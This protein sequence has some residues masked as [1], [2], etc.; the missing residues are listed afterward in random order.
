[1]AM[2]RLLVAAALTLAAVG[3]AAA[4]APTAIDRSFVDATTVIPDLRV[5]LRYARPENF[6]KRAVYPKEAR[7]YLRAPVAA[8]LK[9]VQD[10]LRSQG[11]SLKVWDC[12]RP[13]GVQRQLWELVPDDRYV[14]DPKKGSRHNRG[15]ALDL[16]LVD[17]AARELEMPTA[18]DDFS[19]RAHRSYQ[20]L[21]EAARR[22]RARLE[23]A[24]S[25][26]GFVPLAT[27]W[28]HFDDPD[29]SQF[30]IADES[31]TQL[32]A[33]LPGL[34]ADPDAAIA[35]LLAD[36]LA[37]VG[38]EPI[39]ATVQRLELVHGTHRFAARWKPM[40]PEGREDPQAGS[41]APRCEVAAFRVNRL[42]LGEHSTAEHVVPPTVVR[43]LHRDVP[44]DRACRKL[45]RLVGASLPATF[46]ELNDHLVIGALSTELAGAREPATLRELW[47]PARARRSPHYLRSVGDT[48][49]LLFLLGSGE[50]SRGSTFLLRLPELDRVQVIDSGR[51]F[52]GRPL[53]GGAADPGWR[54]LA[55][56]SPEQLLVP[57]LRRATIARLGTPAFAP[58]QLGRELYL[59]A[60]V[61]LS[62][63]RAVATPAHEPSLAAHGARPLAGL[64]GLTQRGRQTYTG[65][66]Q[67]DGPPWLLLGIGE[68]GVRQLAE[69][70]QALYRSVMRRAAKHP[71]LLL[72]DGDPAP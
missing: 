40:E 39:G 34:P 23:A 19:E 27:E 31:F 63:G 1:M 38:S 21:P 42:L 9:K 52:D 36:D 30:P 5:E 45:P 60:A 3:T 6:T 70:A 28:W 54:P 25:A 48:L 20:A 11:L 33:T 55:E 4:E 46:P 8:R 15:A 7:C 69:R 58:A 65:K 12:Y 14:A 2:R 68:A 32:A 64:P 49:A 50:A 57:A 53:A 22:N 26:A 35:E 43:A 71:E 10:G 44:C 24:M 41:N 18:H 17:A 66:L 51:A 62:S 16:T 37:L 29:S 72:S 59:V 56:L 47:D 61:E 13:L 67:P